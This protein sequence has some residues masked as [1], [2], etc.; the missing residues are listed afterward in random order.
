RLTAAAT[1]LSR[2]ASERLALA[3]GLP[4]PA[5]LSVA[6]RLSISGW[7]PIA[8][9]LSISG[10]FPIAKWLAVAKRLP[11]TRRF[12]VTPRLSVAS[13]RRIL[14]PG[15]RFGVVARG[16]VGLPILER[17]FAASSWPHRAISER[18]EVFASVATVAA[19]VVRRWP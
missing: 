18:F 10:W 13:R 16:R 1:G 9:W 5:R 12:S 19:V 4:C 11:I 17:P 15:T 6:V 14:S 3:E 8:E 2:T 7:F